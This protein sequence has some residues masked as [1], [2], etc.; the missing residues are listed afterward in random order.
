MVLVL[1]VILNWNFLFNPN[2]RFYE[3]ITKS[4][5]KSIHRSWQLDNI[6][7]RG[8]DWEYRPF[9]DITLLQLATSKCNLELLEKIE[10]SLSDFQ[11]EQVLYYSDKVYSNFVCPDYSINVKKLFKLN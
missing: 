7:A 9:D 4:D 3:L 11:K 1:L 8:V 2:D 10:P 5:D 6:I